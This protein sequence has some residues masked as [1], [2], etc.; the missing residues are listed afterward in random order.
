M[1]GR[2]SIGQLLHHIN[3]HVGEINKA[4]FEVKFSFVV[5]HDFLISSLYFD[6]P[7]SLPFY[8]LNFKFFGFAVESLFTF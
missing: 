6:F 4:V 5:F 7:F 8:I 2:L 1:V 3:H